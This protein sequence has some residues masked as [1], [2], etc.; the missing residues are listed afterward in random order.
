MTQSKDYS[1]TFLVDNTPE[2]AFDAINNVRGWWSENIEGRTDALGEFKYRAEDLHRCTIRITELV[3]G[4]RVVWHVLDN[5]FN[6]IADKSEWKD[7]DIIFELAKKGDQTEVRFTHVGL[8]PTYECY[9][10]CSDAWGHYIK[11]SLRSLMTTGKGQPNQN[12]QI[13]HKRGIRSEV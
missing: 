1:A 9:D 4:K 12:E 5:D 7:T 13:T 8:V 3:P 6:F 10:V 11:G 2:A